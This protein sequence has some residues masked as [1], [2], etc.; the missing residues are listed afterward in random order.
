MD[1]DGCL[2]KM[3]MSWERKF[4]WIYPFF[5]SYLVVC[6]FYQTINMGQ[7]V[8]YAQGSTFSGPNPLDICRYLN[9]R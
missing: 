2:D 1:V 8:K 4:V 6:L 7:L 3:V 9:V 5:S